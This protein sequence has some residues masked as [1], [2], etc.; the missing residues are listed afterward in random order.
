MAER[1]A[2]E[3][4]EA[5]LDKVR[6][7]QLAADLGGDPA[8]LAGLIDDFVKESA[9]LVARMRSAA[10]AGNASEAVRAAHS[11]KSSSAALGAIRLSRRCRDFEEAGRAGRIS[12]ASA[13]IDVIVEEAALAQDALRRARDG[14]GRD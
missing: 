10:Q 1:G 7:H 12:D 11:L 8:V 13:R 14:V 2:A 6:F 4:A 3:A 5:V 9:S